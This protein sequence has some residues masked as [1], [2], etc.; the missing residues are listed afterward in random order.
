MPTSI[1]QLKV[2]NN[3]TLAPDGTFSIG[4]RD[5]LVIKPNSQVG[6]SKF[7]YQEQPPID[8]AIVIGDNTT[9]QLNTSAS[10][11]RVNSTRRLPRPVTVN[12]GIFPN[13]YDL[14]LQMNFEANSVLACGD[15]TPSGTT[16]TNFVNQNPLTPT[17]DAGLDIVYSLGQTGEV[18]FSY[19][20]YANQMCL[21]TTDSP[22][23]FANMIEFQVLDDRQD[24]GLIAADTLNWWGYSDALQ[25]V[26]GA[27]QSYIQ[28]TEEG[29]AGTDW[30]WGLRYMEDT[31]SNNGAPVRMGVYKDSA[32]V[33]NLVD[34]GGGDFI[35]PMA[36]YTYASG[37][38][39]VLFSATG[40]L[41]LQVYA[42]NPAGNGIDGDSVGALKY[43]SPP[44]SLYREELRLPE[45]QYRM[46][47]SSGLDYLATPE[48]T[49]TPTF[50]QIYSTWRN[51]VQ[52]VPTPNGV[53][54]VI[55]MDMTTASVLANQFGL[56]PI[57]YASPQSQKTTTFVGTQTPTF[58][59]V[60]DISLFWSLPAHTYVGSQD[61]SRNSR[62]NLVA[63]FTP[64]RMTDNTSNLF[65]Q[66]EVNFTDIGN[67][68]VMNIS[69][70]A[71]RVVN[72]FPYG[73]TPINTS[74][75]SFTLFIKEETK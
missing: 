24:N 19:A 66:E 39:F 41:Y 64:S 55:N 10:L 65:Y 28:V 71:F 46:I 15:K 53:N 57:L 42:G 54:R 7:L 12:K 74:Y 38:F 23:N 75:L 1:K 58:F 37:D 8:S 45:I 3:A 69:T 43:T 33:Y 14:M 44:Y 20:S 68:E 56:S 51:E 5:N 48:G 40:D 13:S 70:I 36:G 47:I 62:E 72:E 21:S 73:K 63:S 67:L 4:L 18:N 35:T 26:K 50:R 30:N 59:R 29:V 31:I 9:F 34:R 16:F 25:S 61:R 52:G 6:L 60:Q 32:G 11:F 49:A 17:I 22:N 2:I 27:I